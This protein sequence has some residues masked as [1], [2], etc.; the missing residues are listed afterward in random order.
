MT[1]SVVIPT[2][3]AGPQLTALLDALRAQQ[4]S[5]PH[6]IIAI[7]SGSTDDTKR[8][9]Q[10]GGG[11]FIELTQPFNHGLARDAGIAAASGELVF[12]TVQDALPAASDCLARMARHFADTRVAGVSSRQVPPADG[13]AELKIKAEIDVREMKRA[14]SQGSGVRSQESDEA[15]SH[16]AVNLADH[17]DYAHYTPEE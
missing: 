9:V 14:K 17:P 6:E 5:A 10:E 15:P 13:P 11:R 3:N 2:F 1:I 7:D 12:L 4:P 16:L 8:R